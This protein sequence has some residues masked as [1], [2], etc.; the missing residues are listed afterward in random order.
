MRYGFIRDHSK[1][2]H[3]ENA[4]RVLNVSVSGYYAWCARGASGREIKDVTERDAALDVLKQ[5]IDNAL[6]DADVVTLV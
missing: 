3:V 4:C 1:E 2:F 5:A 6:Q